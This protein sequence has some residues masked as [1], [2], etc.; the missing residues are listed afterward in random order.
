MSPPCLDDENCTIVYKEPPDA[1]RSLVDSAVEPATT[2]APCTRKYLLL[3][4]PPPLPPISELAQPELRL[5]GFRFHGATYAP[6]RTEYFRD[7]W[8]QRVDD[9]DQRRIPIEGLPPGQG[10]GYVKWAPDGSKVAFCVYDPERG[11]ELWTLDVE[12]RQ[13]RR[14]SPQ[15]LNAVTGEPY[16]W[17]GDS[18]SLLV[19]FVCEWYPRAS[20]RPTVPLGPNVQSNESGAP[21]PGRTYQDLLRDRH[22]MELFDMYTTCQLARVALAPGSAAMPIGAPAPIRR[23]SPS[24]DNWYVLVDCI[25]PPYS[26]MVPASRFPRSV[27]VFS[28]RDGRHVR[29]VADLPLQERIPIAFDGVGEGPRSIGWRADDERAATLVWVEAQDGGDPARVAA[30]RDTLF[31]LRAP[32]DGEP[33]AVLDLARR[34]AGVQWAND[35]LALVT[36]RWWRS[37]TLR[38]YAF[39]PG[40]LLVRGGDGARRKHACSLVFD[41]PNWE[42]TYNDPGDT[43]SRRMRTGK[44]VLRV[45]DGDKLLLAGAGASDAGDRPYLDSFELASGE[46]RRLWQSRPPYFESFVAVLREDAAR[47]APID[48]LTRRQSKSEPP[49]YFSRRLDLDG[50][51]ILPEGLPLAEAT[52]YYEAR[53]APRDEEDNGGDGG[54]GERAA[55]RPAAD[56]RGAQASLAQRHVARQRSNGARAAAA[57]RNGDGGSVLRQLTHF[58][59]PA[60]QL[61]GVQRELVHYTRATD[62]VRLNASLYLPPGYEPRRDGRL[63][64]F[65]WAYPREFKSADAAGQMRDSPYRF[66]RLARS[67][68]YWLT[69][70]YAIL[71]GPAMPIIGERGNGD[72]GD[73]EEEAAEEEERAAREANDTYIEQLVASAEAAVEYVVRRGIA[74]RSRIAIG[75]HSYGAFMTVNLLCHAP[76]LF[77][78]GIAR[79]GAYNRTLTPFGFQSEE[80]TLWQTPELYV[81]MSPYM[82]ADRITA[83]LLLVHGDADNNPGTFPMQ[84]ERLYQALKGHGKTARLVLL[85]HESHG[86]RARESVLHVLYEMCAWLARWCEHGAGARAAEAEAAAAGGR[87]DGGSGAECR[88]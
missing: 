6:S 36:E 63:P 28:L 38:V 87:M 84:S 29:N 17:C 18:Q 30:V 70:G 21:A 5:G 83:P 43:I 64:L 32:F 61:I 26:M 3:L 49:N 50:G 71:D 33:V 1:I 57:E 7:M 40:E 82:Y 48:I 80:R 46:R 78:C 58:P 14:V 77:A 67:P 2:V 76:H 41:V 75:G 31:A 44:A 35:G 37:R 16:T 13:A 68:L 73:G 39:A 9:P 88:L 27:D 42:D 56:S 24:P 4:Q 85:P 79:S 23:A 74:D 22:D 15:R 20:P 25:K 8:L 19:K 86:Y 10:F 59:H 54:S 45:I 69:R 65:M 34:F 81:R 11:L 47:G 60:P 51:V 52:A 55:D 12:T 53:T 72:E 62:G 66:V